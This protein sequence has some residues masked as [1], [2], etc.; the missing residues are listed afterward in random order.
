MRILYTAL[1]DLADG[2]TVDENYE[3]AIQPRELLPTIK[4][5]GQVERA[6][7]G[8]RYA[9]NERTEK[10]WSIDTGWLSRDVEWPIFQEFIASVIRGE[11]FIFDP[12]SFAEGDIVDQRTVYLETRTMRPKVENAG[13]VSYRF[14]VEEQ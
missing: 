9:F 7:D 5:H 14:I 12:Y 3:I 10:R 11:T 6:L 8:T 4:E 1:R 2:H 13:N